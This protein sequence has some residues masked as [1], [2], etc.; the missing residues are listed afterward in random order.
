M[1]HPVNDQII[2]SVIDFVAEKSDG[3]VWKELKKRKII[4]HQSEDPRDIL[5]DAIADEM[6]ERPGPCG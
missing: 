2:D 5:M 1:S 4:L 3:Q 6:F